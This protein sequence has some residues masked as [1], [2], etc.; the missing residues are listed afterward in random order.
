[1]GRSD[2]HAPPLLQ[3]AAKLAGSYGALTSGT[4][5]EGL[6]L[7][8]GA[9]TMSLFLRTNELEGERSA[10]TSAAAGA[11]GRQR[12]AD[13]ARGL[14]ASLYELPDVCDWEDDPSLPPPPWVMDT[15]W[16]RLQVRARRGGGA[17]RARTCRCVA[18]PHLCSCCRSHR[19]L[20]ALCTYR[21]GI[22]LASRWVCRAPCTCL[23]R[24]QTRGGPL[25]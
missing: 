23:A 4:V 18:A 1:M 21:V 16:A 13:A 10:R 5:A 20:M 19:P 17:S 3:A 6:R 25:S 7:L 8:T 2:A 24:A 15:L 11:T 12:P 22:P 9:V 14:S